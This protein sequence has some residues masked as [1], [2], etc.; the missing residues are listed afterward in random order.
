MNSDNDY[1]REINCRTSSSRV[2]KILINFKKKGIDYSHAKWFCDSLRD[3]IE[4][5]FLTKKRGLNLNDIRIY[6]DKY[7][8]EDIGIIRDIYEEAFN[9]KIPFFYVM[10]LKTHFS[11]LL[12]ELNYRLVDDSSYFIGIV[13]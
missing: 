12:L 8:N 11:Q 1:D 13:V 6:I 9:K 7:K 4:K 3:M 10:D 2:R 5:I